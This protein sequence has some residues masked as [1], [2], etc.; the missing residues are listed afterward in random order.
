MSTAS[1]R[2]QTLYGEMLPCSNYDSSC[3]NA[4]ETLKRY[5]VR[6]ERVVCECPTTMKHIEHKESSLVLPWTFCSA[7]EVAVLNWVIFLHIISMSTA[8]TGQLCKR[9]SQEVANICR[10]GPRLVHAE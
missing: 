6:Y 7:W 5:Y 1:N 3:Q 10:P 4:I 9:D 8:V 2:H